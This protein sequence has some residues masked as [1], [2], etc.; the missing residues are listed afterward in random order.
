MHRLATCVAAA[1]AI[2]LIGTGSYAKGPLGSIKVGRWA[3]GAYTNDTTGAFPTA[4][5]VLPTSTVH[6]CSLDN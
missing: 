3:G 6:T 1:A 5:L 4:L 2:T